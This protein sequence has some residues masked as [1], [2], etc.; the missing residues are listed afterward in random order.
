MTLRAPSRRDKIS[1][2]SSA[3]LYAIILYWKSTSSSA[4]QGVSLSL[5]HR[6]PN[7][8]PVVLYCTCTEPGALSSH[9]VQSNIRFNIIMSCSSRWPYSLKRRYE[10]ARL[11]GSRVRIP[12]RAWMF[13]CFV[14]VVC[15]AGSGVCDGL[16]TR[17]EESYR[18]CVC[19]CVCVSNYVCVS[20]CVCVCV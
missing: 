3:L 9:T 8:A 6:V 2:Q 14:F 19:V 5:S 11:L 15:C 1:A 12:L 7:S 17:S 10:A 16:V 4:G 20:D 13:V 18:V